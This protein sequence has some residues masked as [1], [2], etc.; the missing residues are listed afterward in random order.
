VLAL[1][2]VSVGWEFYRLFEVKPTGDVPG[3]IVQAVIA[4]FFWT[5]FLVVLLVSQL[6]IA[7]K[8][9][10]RAIELSSKPAE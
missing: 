1:V 9:I 8:R 4:V 2:T 10:L 3:M 5:L 7:T 6:T